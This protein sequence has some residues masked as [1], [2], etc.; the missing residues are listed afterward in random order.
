MNIKV[1]IHDAAKA[2][3]QLVNGQHNVV[4]VAEAGRCVSLSRNR[5]KIIKKNARKQV[6]HI[7]PKQDLKI[8]GTVINQ[9]RMFS[10]FSRLGAF[11]GS[12]MSKVFFTKILIFVKTAILKNNVQKQAFK[13]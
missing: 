7:K 10:L 5:E 12:L 11:T 13:V 4:H 2:R 3:L 9:N 1:H 8:S 6:L